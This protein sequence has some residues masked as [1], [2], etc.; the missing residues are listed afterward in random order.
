M[1]N[2]E[3]NNTTQHAQPVTTPMKP[4]NRMTEAILVTI[5]PLCCLCNIS[6]LLGIVAIV[7]AN[8][9]NKLYYVG[10]YA[11]AERAAKNAKMWVLITLG[12]VVV[13]FIAYWAYM[14]TIHGGI[15]GFME[16]VREAWEAGRE[17]AW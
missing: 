16:I 6:A 8:Q 2:Q 11:E 5:L 15:D 9:V 4:R 13:T 17:R 7:Y 10:R 12:T 1:E 3:I 14:L